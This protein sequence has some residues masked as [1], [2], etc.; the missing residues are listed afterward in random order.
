MSDK[1]EELAG[2][3]HEQWAY[4]TKYMLD[5]LTPENVDRWERQIDTPYN[6]LNEK[7]KESDRKWARKAIEI[8][9]REVRQ[10]KDMSDNIKQDTENSIYIENIDKKLKYNGSITDNKAYKLCLL[11]ATDKEMA[12]IIGI[13][14]STLNEWKKQY[15]SLSE[16]IKRGKRDADAEVAES[17]FKKATGKCTTT[18]VKRAVDENG[19]T[20]ESTT[21]KENMPDTLAAMY[22]LNNRNPDRW[23]QKQE[24]DHNVSVKTLTILPPEEDVKELQEAEEPKLIEE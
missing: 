22:W 7:E 14:E 6:E 19:K 10:V 24:I 17:L 18:E 4:W 15:P 2:L 1:L 9:G 20:T 3:E 16:S 23:K 5:N 13:T 11:G 21:V 12:E 8:L